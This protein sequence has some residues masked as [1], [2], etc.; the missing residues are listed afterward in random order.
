MNFA[1]SI[2]HHKREVP[3]MTAP[4]IERM[5]EPQEVP[6]RRLYDAAT[7]ASYLGL[8]T[9]TLAMWRHQGKGPAYVKIGRAAYYKPEEIER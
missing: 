8:Q 5:S 3:E 1:P 2:R 9:A 4:H 6:Q 7:T